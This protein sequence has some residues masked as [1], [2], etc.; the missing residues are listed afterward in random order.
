MTKLSSQ[1]PPGAGEGLHLLSDDLI[2]NPTDHHYVIGIVDC[3]STST[4]TD[5]GEVTPTARFRRIEAVAP[6]DLPEVQ[7]MLSRAIERR[8]GQRA[9]PLDGDL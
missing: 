7:Q 5:S 4:E 1:L 9:L 2:D 8:T 3:K 6:L